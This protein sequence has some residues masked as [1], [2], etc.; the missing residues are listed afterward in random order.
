MASRPQ[1]ET[2]ILAV[3]SINKAV[4]LK[5]LSGCWGSTAR[6][7]CA[8][9]G[10]QLLSSFCCN[11]YIYFS[12]KLC[13]YKCNR[14]AASTAEHSKLDVVIPQ[15][16]S[17][18]LKELSGCWGS[19]ARQCCAADGQ[20]LLSSFCCN[21]YIYFSSKL[22]KYRC[23]RSAISTAEHSKLDHALPQQ[24]SMMLKEHSGCWGIASTQCWLAQHQ[25]L[26]SSFCGDAYKCQMHQQHDLQVY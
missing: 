24:G 9:D 11:C 13:K 17:V 15:Q 23:N 4:L 6:Q 22:C 14:S 3:S 10:Q 16:G 5:E 21:C 19:T 8:A 2:E 18:L 26:L 7:C 12:S 1:Q 20:Q 25:Q